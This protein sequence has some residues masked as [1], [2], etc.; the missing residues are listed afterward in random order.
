MM[1]TIMSALVLARS[2]GNPP[3]GDRIA[4]RCV[5]AASP[6]KNG[7][8]QPEV[9]R[10]FGFEFVFKNDAAVTVNLSAIHLPFGDLGWGGSAFFGRDVRR[11]LGPR[12][13]PLKT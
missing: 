10:S 3:I 13:E 12:G 6:V 9:D 11:Q 8:S 4:V 5:T 2:V 1:A 7:V